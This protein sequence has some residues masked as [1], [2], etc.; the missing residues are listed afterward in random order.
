MTVIETKPKGLSKHDMRGRGDG[1][2]K[3]NRIRFYFAWLHT[4]NTW[5]GG[6]L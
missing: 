5:G 1:Y 4:T 3:E 6:G 2:T